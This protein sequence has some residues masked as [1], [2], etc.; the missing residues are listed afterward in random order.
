[1]DFGIAKAITDRRADLHT[2]QT[3]HTPQTEIGRLM[4]T[5]EYM[6]P[7]QTGSGGLDVDTRSDVYSLGVI[8]YQLLTGELPFEGPALGAAGSDALRAMTVKVDPPRPPKG[9]GLL[10]SNPPAD[11]TRPAVLDVAARRSVDAT[12]LRRILRGD[13]DW[14]VMKALEKDRGRRY[15]SAS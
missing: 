8:L 1:I 7:E 6:S 14:I 9:L 3:P 11:G 13:L 2:P 5:P 10:L 15:D 12:S 4:G